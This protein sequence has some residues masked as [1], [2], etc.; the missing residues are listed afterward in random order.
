MTDLP[1]PLTPADCDLRKFPFMPLDAQRLRDSDIASLST[2]DEFR[3]AV[4]LWCASWHQVPAGSIPDDDKVLSKL[5]GFGFA[6]KEWQKC[7]A[8]ALRGWIKCSDDRLYHPIVCEKALEGW[9]GRVKHAEK[10][11][12]ERLRKAEE[13]RLRKLAEDARLDSQIPLDTGDMSAGQTA[14]VRRT[15]AG[16][17][18]DFSLKGKGD[19]DSGQW[20]VDSGQLTS[21]TTTEP[22]RVDFDVNDCASDDDTP[23]TP[24]H[25]GELCIAMRAAGVMTQPAD[26][27]MLALAAQ[28]IEPAT[29]TAAC[30]E[31]KRA[32][33][34]EPV[35][36]GYVLA[37][38]DRWAKDAAAMRVS[39]AA[40]PR[41]SPSGYQTANDK[42]KDLA[43]RLTGKKR[44]DQPANIIDINDAPA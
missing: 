21:K 9:A 14:N 10:K 31:A 17:P 4:L 8:G 11:E 15:D 13:R 36:P 37:I 22:G 27:R 32:K 23:P 24:S 5:A 39:G 3:C 34:N 19:K 42:A 2:G 35:K 30:E 16:N 26:P 38:L 43:D 7:R 1:Q 6:V 44:H 12:A 20:T 28:G 25:V 40:Q 33:P 18:Q 29:V 41:A